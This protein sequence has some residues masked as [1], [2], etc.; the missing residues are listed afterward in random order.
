[1]ANITQTTLAVDEAAE[2][3]AALQRRFPQLHGPRREDICYAT[4]NRQQ[5]VK[6]IA[7][8]CDAMLIV[9]APNSSNSMRLVE[10]A[11]AAG[12]AKAWLVRRAADIDW[13]WLQGVRRLGL[14]AGASAP[15]L[16][17]QEVIAACRERFAVTVE[18]LAVTEES[19]HFKLPRALTA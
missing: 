8:D 1:V 2:I 13:R 12:C 7:L 9:G 6:A 4:T 5:A 10:V 14:T 15:E 17:V 3:I 16:L 19:V 11:K 18:E